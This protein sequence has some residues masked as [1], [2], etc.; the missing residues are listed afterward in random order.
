MSSCASDTVV[1]PTKP[2]S[3]TATTTGPTQSNVSLQTWKIDWHD[4]R[5]GIA[6]GARNTYTQVQFGIARS[7]W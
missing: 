5:P 2:I 1:I 4:D 6:S 3:T 7:L